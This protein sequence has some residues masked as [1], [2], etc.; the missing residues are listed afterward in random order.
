MVKFLEEIAVEMAA[1][2]AQWLAQRFT[3]PAPAGQSNGA[4][5][6]AL[7]RSILT[8]AANHPALK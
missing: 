5:V 6:N 8:L 7:A 1:F 3:P 4:T 2:F